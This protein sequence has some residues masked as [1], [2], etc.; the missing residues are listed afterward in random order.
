MYKMKNGEYLAN[1]SNIF[2][3]ANN[4]AYSL[5]IVITLTMLSINLKQIFLKKSISYSGAKTWNDLPRSLKA[6]N[7]SSGQFRTLLRDRCT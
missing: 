2:N 1:I 6:S 3:V 5:R 4:Q 7:I